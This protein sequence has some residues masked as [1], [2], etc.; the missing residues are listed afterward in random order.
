MGHYVWHDLRLRVEPCALEARAQLPELFRKLSIR[1]APSARDDDHEIFLR[2]DEKRRNAPASATLRF[3][4]DGFSGF[5]ADDFSYLTDG[6]SLFSTQSGSAIGHASLAESFFD[7]PVRRQASFWAFSLL[8]TARPLGLYSLHAAALV[9]PDGRGLLLFGPGGSGKSTLTLGLIRMGWQYLSDDALLLR[10]IS[11]RL[12][13]LALRR[14]FYLE[15]DAALQN[16]DLP[17]DDPVCDDD[18]KYK[19]RVRLEETSFGTQQIDRYVP[20][21][22][23]R[24]RIVSDRNSV[25]LPLSHSIALKEL[26]E[27]SGSQLFDRHSMTN[28]VDVLN[29][30]LGQCAT[31]ELRAGQDIYSDAAVL[32]RLLSEAH[33]P[34]SPCGASLSS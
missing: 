22:L 28:Q 12:Q 7:Q 16:R 19:R 31:H 3:H 14:D 10:I 23:L 34:E 25:L 1:E 11:D 21:V 20:S 2:L 6:S 33:I 15:A 29:K 26:L 9:M 32:Q 5:D 13:A 8:K 4:V 24:T 27:A 17:F 18:G 30:L